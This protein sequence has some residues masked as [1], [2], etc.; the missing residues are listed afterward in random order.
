MLIYFESLEKK[1]FQKFI[2][3]EFWQAILCA[4]RIITKV[5]DLMEMYIP[6]TRALLNEKNHGKY[7]TG[8]K[9][10]DNIFRWEGN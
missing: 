3:L 8:A 6:S 7:F 10:F 9:V 1:K 2:I 4:Y 5:P